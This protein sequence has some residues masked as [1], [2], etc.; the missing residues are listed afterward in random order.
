MKTHLVGPELWPFLEPLIPKP[1][2]SSRGGRPRL[3]DQAVL[4][5]ILFVLATGIPWEDLPQSL[6]FGSAMT[7]WRRLRDWQ[8]HGVW[9]RLHHVLLTRLRQS[10]QIDWSRASLDSASVP[11][12]RG[13]RK[14]GQIPPTAAN[15]APSATSL[16]IVRG[17]R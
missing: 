8:Q 9:D 4:N 13:A 7:G 11:S 15:S 6:G 16:S 10:D 17:F 14:R 1:V 2:R 3:D 5:G 12:P